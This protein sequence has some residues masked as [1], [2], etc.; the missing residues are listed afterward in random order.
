MEYK[1]KSTKIERLWEFCLSVHLSVC[2]VRAGIVT[3]QPTVRQ[4]TL[5]G[6][7]RTSLFRRQRSWCNCNG[8]IPSKSAK[9]KQGPKIGIFDQY[10]DISRKRYSTGI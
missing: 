2:H 5:Y 9:Y 10:V 1:I 7:L 4:A 3:K 6:S 8:V